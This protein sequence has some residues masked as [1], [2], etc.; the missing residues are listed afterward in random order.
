VSF[1]TAAAALLTALVVGS[2]LVAQVR[3]PSHVSPGAPLVVVSLG[4]REYEARL[5]ADGDTVAAGLFAK[6][7]LVPGF[8]TGVLFLGID[9]TVEPGTYELELRDSAGG[10]L[11]RTV[12]VEPREFRHEDVVLSSTL[13]DLRTSDDPRKQVETRFLQDLTAE[14]NPTA[15]Y[16]LGSYLWPIELTRRTSLFGDRRTYLYS[17]GETA[18]S[19]HI[20][21]DLASPQGTVVHASGAGLVRMARNRIVTG[22]TV[23]IEHLPG[24]FSLYY[25]LRDLSV[26][27]G[28]R[29]APGQPIGS[30]G[31]TGLAT[32]PH[33]HWEFRIGGVSVDPESVLPGLAVDFDS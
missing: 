3:V 30:V 18:F 31:A 24:V 22:N 5:N 6:I 33:L 32:G 8:P 12:V 13:S 1:R 15:I 9:S 29:V 4:D 7:A 25:H 27:E 11:T 14:F 23:V 21:L 16:H 17:D 28:D 10:S 2:P 20:G 26:T 19:I